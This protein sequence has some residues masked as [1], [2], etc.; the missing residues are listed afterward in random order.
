[1]QIPDD[2]AWLAVE[3][4]DRRC[5]GRFVFAVRT[6]GIYCRP[7]CP[8]RRPHRHNVAFFDDTAAAEAA[9]F[10][11]CMRCRP[12]SDEGSA[13]E[14]SVQ[15]A[16]AFLEAHLDEAVTLERLSEAVG[17][18]AWHL[19]RIFKARLGLSPR[20]WQEARRLDRLRD[21]LEA[22]ASVTQAA[23][24]AGFNSSR[25]LY[26]SVAEGLG[27]TP[28]DYRRGGRGLAIRYTLTDTAFGRA[29]VAATDRGV[30]AVSLG[31]DDARLEAGLEQQFPRATRQRDDAALGPWVE[32]ILRQ[33]EGIQ[34]GL[35]VPL[36]L[37]GTAFQM[38]VWNALREIPRGQTR[39]YAQV[40]KA[41]GE[42]RAIRAVA[43]AIARNPV[44]LVVPC[45]RVIHGDGSLSGYRWGVEVKRRVL[46]RE[47]LTTDPS[48]CSTPPPSSG[49]PSPAWA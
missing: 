47:R 11:A 18:S 31:G 29:L 45:H 21:G 44:A 33:I 10:R 39:S 30:C 38:R 48:G 37:Q 32:S 22:G 35:A 36:D 3:Q 17:M 25:G 19:Q 24:D 42:P 4:R 14:R 15:E 1:M 12:A 46:A 7:S 34:P 6:T 40:A 8:S 20:A 2:A 13:S 28:G 41:I 5:D 23:Y 16:L 27:M 9:G 26:E 49:R 43:S